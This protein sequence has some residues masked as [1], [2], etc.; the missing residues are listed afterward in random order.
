MGNLHGLDE[1]VDH[2]WKPTK[3]TEYQ[4]D[5]KAFARTFLEKDSEWWEKDRDDDCYDFIFHGL[6]SIGIY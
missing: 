6:Y 4:V 5:D 3:D 1:S 2:T